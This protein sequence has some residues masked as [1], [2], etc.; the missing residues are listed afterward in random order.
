MQVSFL[1]SRE[2]WEITLALFAFSLVFVIVGRYVGQKFFSE[3]EKD[4]SVTGSV[5]A[6]LG[7]MLAF[8][9]GMS[10][11]R[12]EKRIEIIINESNNISTAVLRANLYPESYRQ[13]FRADFKQYV[14]ARI[15]LFE[16]GA[17]IKKIIA[18]QQESEKISQRIWERATLLSKDTTVIFAATMQ[19]IPALNE[20]MDISNTR[21]HMSLNKVPESVMY[22]LFILICICAFQ[23]GYTLSAK[24]KMDWLGVFGVL[25]LVS[26]VIYLIIDMDRPRR[27]TITLKQTTQ[28]IVDLRKMFE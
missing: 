21:W 16:A 2:T 12:Y 23:L 5:F 28:S 14:E 24:K 3:H 1:L 7:L 8:T 15:A 10:L 11:T 4:S 20:M 27:G 17:D 9:F 13:Q 26:I 6:I 19:M 18:A 25:L 22:L